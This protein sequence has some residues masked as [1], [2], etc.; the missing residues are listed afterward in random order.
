MN[1]VI[2]IREFKIIIKNSI[3]KKFTKKIVKSKMTFCTKH[4][5]IMYFVKILFKTY[6]NSIVKKNNNENNNFE[7]DFSKNE[8]SNV[9]DEISKKKN[10]INFKH[11]LKLFE[12]NFKKK[13]KFVISKIYSFRNAIKSKL[14]YFLINNI[15]QIS[16][17]F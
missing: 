7:N 8:L 15:V 11:D 16:K 17:Q 12:S 14:F 1:I 13:F 4:I 9:D 2:H 10:L 3:Q 5:L 6:R